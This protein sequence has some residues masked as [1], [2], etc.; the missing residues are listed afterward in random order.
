VL[1]RRRRQGSTATAVSPPGPP[2]TCPDGTPFQGAGHLETLERISRLAR[3]PGTSHGQTMTR[4]AELV[5][6]LICRPDAVELTTQLVADLGDL[7]RLLEANHL[8]SEAREYRTVLG[9][10]NRYWDQS[11]ALQWF[12]DSLK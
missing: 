1:G 4:Q 6:S 12:R 11:G 7:E 3:A 8:H 10:L 9:D 5:K 2:A